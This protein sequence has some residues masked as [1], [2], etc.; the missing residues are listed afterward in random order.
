[1]TRISCRTG[2]FGSFTPARAAT[3][4]LQA[5]AAFTTTSQPRVPASV[6][7]DVMRR[8]AVSNP[9]TR[10]KVKTFAPSASARDAYPQT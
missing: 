3:S 8:P 4:L 7:T 6:T 1:M 2:T 5:P 9:V 10:V